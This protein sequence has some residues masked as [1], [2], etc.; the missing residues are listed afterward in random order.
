MMV[1]VGFAN[2]N[3]E[4]ERRR[5]VLFPPLLGAHPLAVAIETA[6]C[7]EDL[8]HKFCVAVDAD[9]DL[10]LGETGADITV[11]CGDAACGIALAGADKMARVGPDQAVE[12]VRCL[13]RV[14]A[15]SGI[16]RMRTFVSAIGAPGVFTAASLEAG[17]PAPGRAPR[18]SIGWLA[19]LNVF[20]VGLPFGCLSAESLAALAGLAELHG[21]STLRTTPWRVLLLPGVAELKATSVAVE[22]LGLITDPA[23]RRRLIVA[24]IGKR[25]CA[26]ASVDVQADARRMLDLPPTGFVH[27]S[28]CA[29]GVR[30]SRACARHAGWG[31]WSI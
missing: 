13:A 26:A 17:T 27:L 29:K 15:A 7:R 20:G 4:I 8:P 22:K 1:E 19:D 31:G 6:L 2:P 28:G 11:I 3:P 30:P 5:T 9:P 21:D 10:P 14:L 18:S 25:G 16:R 23:D 24:C 12:S